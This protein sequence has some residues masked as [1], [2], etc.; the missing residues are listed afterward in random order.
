M[1]GMKENERTFSHLPFFEFFCS[2]FPLFVYGIILVRYGEGRE[3]HR[4]SLP[5][6]RGERE[7]GRDGEY[8]QRKK[9]T[10]AQE[11]GKQQILPLFLFFVL[12]SIR[13]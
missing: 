12:L 9:E 13:H 5:T 7:T 4:N 2:F 1:D 6:H 8:K 3:R 10:F 11:R